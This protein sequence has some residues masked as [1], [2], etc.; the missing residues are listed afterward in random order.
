MAV[1]ISRGQY[2]SC[3]VGSTVKLCTMPADTLL[4]NL[5]LL[6]GFRN[7]LPV[8]RLRAKHALLCAFFNAVIVDTSVYTAERRLELSLA[9]ASFTPAH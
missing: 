4:Q 3:L 8:F 2:C 7:P 5:K 1:L 6:R 9:G